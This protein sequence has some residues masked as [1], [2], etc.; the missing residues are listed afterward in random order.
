[1]TDE[2]RQILRIQM[3]LTTFVKR[4]KTGQV[5]RAL[6][7]DLGGEG[8]CMIAEEPFER[9]TQ[10]E[11]KIKLPDRKTPIVGTGEVVWC[12]PL[13]PKDVDH[14]SM[15]SDIGVHF[16]AIDPNDAT[17]L[18]QFARLHALPQ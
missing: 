14:G 4:L 13:G 5:Q 11:L 8:L 16:T 18:A 3:K 9:G 17:V 2:R 12:K 1:M 6:T 10:V 7:R 15:T